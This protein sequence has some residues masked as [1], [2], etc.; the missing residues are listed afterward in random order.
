M[1]KD[2][3]QEHICIIDRGN[4]T[5]YRGNFS[6]EVTSERAYEKQSKRNPK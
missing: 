2:N 5:Y 4:P 3:D 1:I 6:L